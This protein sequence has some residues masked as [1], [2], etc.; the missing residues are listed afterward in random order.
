ME[1]HVCVPPALVTATFNFQSSG[2]RERWQQRKAASPASI[3]EI[4]FRVVNLWAAFKSETATDPQAIR[5]RA[6]EI[7]GD[8]KAWGQ[9]LPSYW[10]Y[11]TVDDG[12]RAAEA[13]FGRIRH[14]YPGLWV[15][16]VWNNWRT[17]RIVIGHILIHNETRSVRPDSALEA[18]ALSIIHQ[19]SVDICVSTSSFNGDSRKYLSF[20]TLVCP[21]PEALKFGHSKHF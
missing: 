11:A 18:F 9:S 15:A 7:D 8:L 1:Q 16:N 14:E 20:P 17:L 19:M 3:C 2:I 21:I 12:E 6:L 5:A 4:S 10:K 13:S